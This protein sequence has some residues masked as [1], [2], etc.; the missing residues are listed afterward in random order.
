VR[1]RT[2]ELIQEVALN[3]DVDG[4]DL[5][6]LRHPIHFPETMRG[7]P[8]PGAKA[9]LITQLTRDVREMLD[10]IGGQRGR[11]ILL[12][13]RVPMLIQHAVYL[14]TDVDG[15]LQEGLIDMVVA[16]GGYIPFSMPNGELVS[17]GHEHDVPVHPCISASGMTRRKP[18]GPGGVYGIEAWR[19]ASAN[20]FA[21]GAD[22]ISLFNLFPAP[23]SD[24]HNRLARQVFAE[25]GDPATL[26][27]K[28]K[29]FCLDSAAHLDNCGYTNHVID[30]RHCL[31]KAIPPDG[32]LRLELPVGESVEAASAARLRV[33][34]SAACQLDCRL[35]DQP[36]ELQPS[37]ELNGS[38]GMSWLTADVD[39][40]TLTAGR[41]RC[42]LRV[43]GG[44]EGSVDV[45]GLELLVTY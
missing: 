18:Y 16:G 11:P 44:A 38:I 31:P 13:V 25:A 33:Q 19:A 4:I 8:V 5:D 41:N 39:P 3:Y 10:R 43:A 40:V 37:P 45:T 36:L 42:E 2:K 22:G 32:E 20:A 12:S 26:A 35:E 34:T 23:G 6:W 21:A 30:Y 9:A 28:D 7:E 1:Q 14:G 24:A 29:L 17:L 15:W 27:G